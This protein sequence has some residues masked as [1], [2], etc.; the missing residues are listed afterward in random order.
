[1]GLDSSTLNT[2]QIEF[3]TYYLFILRV[4]QRCFPVLFTGERV[5]YRVIVNC[6]GQIRLITEECQP[7]Q[8][9]FGHC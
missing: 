3:G 7:L 6:F 2:V 4:S 1:M 9:I 5:D 8:T